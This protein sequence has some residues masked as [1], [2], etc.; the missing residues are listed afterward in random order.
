VGDLSAKFSTSSA[1]RPRVAVVPRVLDAEQCA[2]MAK[3]MRKTLVAVGGKK[4]FD[5]LPIDK[6]IVLDPPDLCHSGPAW[7]ARKACAPYFAAM[8]G[9]GDLWCSFDRFNVY[10]PGQESRS[11]LHSDQS[12]L[13]SGLHCIQGYLDVNGTRA[14]DP[15][16][17]VAEGSHLEHEAL[18]K[19]WNVQRAAHWYMLKNAEAEACRKRFPIRHIQCPPGSLVLWDSRTL[20]ENRGPLAGGHA[21]L[22][23]YVCMLPRS[24]AKSAGEKRYQALVEKRQMCFNERYCTSHWP[25]LCNILCATKQKSGA[26]IGGSKFNVS[27]KIIN[28]PLLDKDAMVASLAS[29]GEEPAL[30][31]SADPLVQL[32][33][34]ESL[35]LRE[36]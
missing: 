25:V 5:T 10:Q 31:Y 9:T 8:Y 28:Q 22:V 19:Q 11:W 7:E 16:L 21:R 30:D 18:M 36:P 32:A 24:V 27:D 3:E 29:F 33:T 35:Y 2:R 15:G 20:H 4:C 17:Q 26:K 13:L 14:V 1:D 23:F 12:G 6:G 34:A